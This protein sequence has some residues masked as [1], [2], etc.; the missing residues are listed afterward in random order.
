MEKVIDK[1]GR[2][3]LSQGFTN[4][5]GINEKIVY[6]SKVEKGLFKVITEKDAQDSNERVDYGPIKMD[7]KSR[8]IIP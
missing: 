7:E 1:H 5:L 4:L 6:L 3:N 2:L 8:I